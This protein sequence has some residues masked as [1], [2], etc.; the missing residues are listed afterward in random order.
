[1]K[2]VNKAAAIATII[3][4]AFEANATSINPAE[5]GLQEG[6]ILYSATGAGILSYKPYY[7][8]FADE[9]PITILAEIS[10]EIPNLVTVISPT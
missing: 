7:D 9:F 1:M 3:F 10:Y 5:F 4:T 8:G 2:L 6:S